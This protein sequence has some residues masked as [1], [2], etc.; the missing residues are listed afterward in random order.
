MQNPLRAGILGLGASVPPTVRGNA[1]PVFSFALAASPA[2]SV[3][4]AGMVERRVLAPNE[5]LIDLMVD[6]ATSALRSA[7]TEPGEIDRLIG[8]ESVSQNLTPNGLYLLHQKLGLRKNVWV[9]P[10]NCDFSN[11]LFGLSMAAESISFGR[12][13]KSLIVC[14]SNWSRFVDYHKPHAVLAGDGAGAAVVGPCTLTE[15]SEKHPNALSEHPPARHIGASR[16]SAAARFVIVDCEVETDSAS[17]DLWTMRARVQDGPHGR[18]LPIDEAGL[19]IPTYELAKDASLEFLAA[20][21][22][23]PVR[24]SKTILRK[25]GVH[26]SDITLIPHHTKALMDGWA[27]ALQP[28]AVLHTLETFGNMSHASIAVTLALKSHEIT[29]SH[30]LLVSVGPGSHF[31]VML[32]R[33]VAATPPSAVPRVDCGNDR[34]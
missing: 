26:P 21:V 29:T 3:L 18:Y 13:S 24:L 9:L 30:V 28:K 6:A 12:A 14:G 19:P 10:I 15:P 8:Y 33:N 5:K 34:P 32:L 4:T 27:A 20:G 31:A 7:E 22:E 23:I 17:F 1:D 2:V 16:A 11:F 25:H